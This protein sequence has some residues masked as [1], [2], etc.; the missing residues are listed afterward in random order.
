MTVYNWLLKGF[1][2]IVFAIT[3][4]TPGEEFCFEAS[5]DIIQV[6]FKFGSVMCGLMLEK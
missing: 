4:P 2:V 6:P 5:S 1:M 3:S